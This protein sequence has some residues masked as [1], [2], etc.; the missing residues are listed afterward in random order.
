MSE[1]SKSYLYLIKT[2]LSIISA[3]LTLGATSYFY[4]QKTLGFN[5][6]T[7]IDNEV[8]MFSLL[9][10][11]STLSLVYHYKTF[12]LVRKA[13]N[14]TPKIPKSTSQFI[15]LTPY[16]LS[17]SIFNTIVYF[18]INPAIKMTSPIRDTLSL[19][20]ILLSINFLSIYEVNQLKKINDEINIDKT[21]GIDQTGKP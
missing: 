11:A 9:G 4:N 8:I 10:F 18:T 17:V 21:P 20:A 1:N 13:H 2:L 5:L 15:W 3:F 7:L 16:I 14:K 19:L 12:F 6:H